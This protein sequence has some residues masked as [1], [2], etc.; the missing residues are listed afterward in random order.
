MCRIQMP[1]PHRVV[2]L[3]VHFFHTKYDAEEHCLSRIWLFKY[4]QT[5]HSSIHV[6]RLEAQSIVSRSR[7]PRFEIRSGHLGSNLT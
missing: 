6:G 2:H 3:L 7:G 1:T 4:L 5:Q